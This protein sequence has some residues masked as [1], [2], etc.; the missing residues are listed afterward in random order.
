MLN[1]PVT[2]LTTAA[3]DAALA[4]VSAAFAILFARRRTGNRWRMGLWA[5]VFG[6]T[7]LGS[8]L[9]AAAHGLA[10]GATVRW[11]LWQPLY[12]SL[13]L[14]VALFLVAAIRDGFGEARARR[15]LPAALAVG[16]VFYAITEIGG[17]SFG[18]FVAY[19][20]VAMLAALII[21]IRL[22]AGGRRGA[23]YVA[24]GIALTLAA[25]GVQA[26]PFS[27]TVVWPLDHNALFHLVQLAALFVLAHGVW[28]GEDART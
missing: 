14:T 5:W 6:L 9:G 21:Y 24:A 15:S 22:A 20:A 1:G 17:G 8:A 16:A 19:E 25:A 26:S 7:A 2:E 12:L 3:T 18:L 28:H 27:L 13:G 23:G 10:L 11:A 4:V